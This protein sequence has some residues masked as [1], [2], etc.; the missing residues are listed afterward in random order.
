MSALEG[1]LRPRIRCLDGGSD[2]NSSFFLSSNCFGWFC[3]CNWPAV[4]VRRQRHQSISPISC[5]DVP[6]EDKFIRGD[7]NTAD[8]RVAIAI[9][10]SLGGPLSV[11]AS[12]RVCYGMGGFVST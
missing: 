1:K 7:A 10:I 11:S 9:A 12:A 2:G 8:C 5:T 4:S 6:N 3:V